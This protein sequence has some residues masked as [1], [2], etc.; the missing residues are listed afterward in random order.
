MSIDCCYCWWFFCQYCMFCL[1]RSQQRSVG[2]K[3]TYL[4]TQHY[5][6]SDW[7][8]G[9]CILYLVWLLGD[10][11]FLF[12]ICT[13]SNRL[14]KK[15]LSKIL[16]LLK[17]NLKPYMYNF[18][19]KFPFM[20]QAQG[21]TKMLKWSHLLLPESPTQMGGSGTGLFSLGGVVPHPFS[22]LAKVWHRCED[23][24]KLL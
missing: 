16:I 1:Q 20:R 2:I 8:P 3:D 10:L 17:K 11:C 6:T 7:W 24:K 13:E 22:I 23:L 12:I 21:L 9:V 14:Q 4:Q 5:Q 19:E 15:I 18:L